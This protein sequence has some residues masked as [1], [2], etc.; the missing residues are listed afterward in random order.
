MNYTQY[1]AV[2]CFLLV[3]ACLLAFALGWHARGDEIYS[4]MFNNTVKITEIKK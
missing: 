3:P 1:T 2:F 4:S